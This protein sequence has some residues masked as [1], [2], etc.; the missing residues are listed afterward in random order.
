M[1][2]LDLNALLSAVMGGNA[3]AQQRVENNNDLMSQFASQVAQRNR[4]T[5]DAVAKVEEAK[6]LAQAKAEEQALYYATVLGTNPDATS[7]V[8]TQYITEKNALF[9][10]A[11]ANLREYHRQQQTTILNPVQWIADQASI[12]TTAQQYN[13]AADEYN[14]VSREIDTIV[15]QTKEIAQGVHAI[16]NANTAETAKLNAQVAAS[17]YLNL[18]DAA[19]MEGLKNNTAGILQVQGLKQN[20]LSVGY[21]AAEHAMAQERM[22]LARESAA[23]SRAAH[24]R[25]MAKDKRDDEEEEQALQ[26]YNAFR[27]SMGLPQATRQTFGLAYKSDPKGTMDEVQKGLITLNSAKDGKGI[28]R[29]LGDTPTETL[30]VLQK[31]GA[32]GLD[33]PRQKVIG[34]LGDAVAQAAKS[35]EGAAAKTAQ[36]QAA[37]IDKTAINLAKAA[38]NVIT[39]QDNI[40][41]PPPIKELLS[42]PGIAN[43]IVGQ[44]ILSKLPEEHKK[45]F[46]PRVIDDQVI[47]FIAKNPAAYNQVVNEMAYIGA[48]AIGYNNATKD[49]QNTAG[50]PRQTSINVKLDETGTFKNMVNEATAAVPN[51]TLAPMFRSIFGGVSSATVDMADPAAYAAHLNKRLASRVFKKDK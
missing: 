9:D 10:E 20:A 28:I 26:G 17:Q 5:A 44:R 7:E 37:V 29:S 16:K 2:G 31:Y 23:Q 48:K 34:F 24:A 46:N 40:Y 3:D 50:L 19:E 49:Y 33:A 30:K 25:A 21:Q 15:S 39:S 36:Q 6:G 47:A 42:D 14:L 1:A 35:P 32:N 13:A 8:L 38:H 12:R 18:A 4:D 43:T 22:A 51:A 41:S 45:E 27:V 11:R